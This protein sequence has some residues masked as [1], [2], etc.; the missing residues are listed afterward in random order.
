M[1]LVKMEQW[2]LCCTP[3]KMIT[4]EMTKLTL[5][6]TVKYNNVAKSFAL[7]NL[8]SKRFFGDSQR[9]SQHP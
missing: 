2:I 1:G 8:S 5:R 3:I 6:V 9:C 4:T 7:P